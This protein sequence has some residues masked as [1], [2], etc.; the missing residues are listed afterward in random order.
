MGQKCP[1]S[2]EHAP[3]ASTSICPLYSPYCEFWEAPKVS[4]ILIGDTDYILL[5]GYSVFSIRNLILLGSTTKKTL[6]KWSGFC[7]K[8]RSQESSKDG[9]VLSGTTQKPAPATLVEP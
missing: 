1:P 2:S 8:R 7:K 9:P 4:S 6:L 5:L 3:A